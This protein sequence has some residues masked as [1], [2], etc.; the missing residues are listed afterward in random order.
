MKKHNGFIFLKDCKRENATLYYSLLGILKLD[1]VF[2]LKLAL[3]TYKVLNE[4]AKPIYFLILLLLHHHDTHIIPD[5]LHNVIFL[6]QMHKQII[7]LKH[8]YY[9]I[10]N[11]A[12]HR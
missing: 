12:D 5:F 4:K 10:E 2:K 6:D 7:E 8:F 9:F 3:F 1:S 11:H